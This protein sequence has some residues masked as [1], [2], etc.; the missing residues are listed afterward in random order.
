MKKAIH[1]IINTF[2]G[3][4]ICIATLR[5]IYTIEYRFMREPIVTCLKNDDQ[6]KGQVFTHVVVDEVGK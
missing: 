4:K 3:Y 1:W 5:H 2:K 6:L